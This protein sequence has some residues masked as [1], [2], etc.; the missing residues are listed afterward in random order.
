MM[1]FQDRGYLLCYNVQREILGGLP[2]EQKRSE[3]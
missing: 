2:I 1:I 3:G